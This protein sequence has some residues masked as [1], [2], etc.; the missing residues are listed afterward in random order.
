M[1]HYYQHLLK[2]SSQTRLGNECMS[3]LLIAVLQVRRKQFIF[4]MQE[5]FAVDFNA[6]LILLPLCENKGVPAAKQVC[7]TAQRSGRQWDRLMPLELES[8]LQPASHAAVLVCN[9]SG[10]MSV[11]LSW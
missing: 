2:I 10:S 5:V 9:G 3:F 8:I 1:S 11:V 4:L 6:F 7:H